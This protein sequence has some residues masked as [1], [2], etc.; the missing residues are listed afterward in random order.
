VATALAGPPICEQL[1]CQRSQ[2]KRVV[3][4]AIG[5][6]SSIGGDDRAAKLQGQAAV[7][8]EPKCTRFRSPAGFAIATCRIPDKLLIAISES[9]HALRKSARHLANAG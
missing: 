9:R 2:S 1:T 5:Q 3:K 8:I 6:Q 7:E 4:F